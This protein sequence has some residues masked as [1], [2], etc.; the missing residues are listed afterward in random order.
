[1]VMKKELIAPCGMNCGLCLHY[2]RAENKCP[3]C[4]SG[5]KVS[6]RCIKCTIK[7]CKDR[8]GEYCFNC[9]KFPCERL[10]KLDKRYR[11]RYGMS[12]IGNLKTIKK[13][14]ID[15]LLAEEEQ[16]WVN[17][18]GTYCVHDKKLYSNE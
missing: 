17:S 5:R 16:K 18:E 13:N 14:G 10:E 11:E 2:L 1:M 6:G 12:E 9:D 15:A 8:Q 4:S 3:G 7:L